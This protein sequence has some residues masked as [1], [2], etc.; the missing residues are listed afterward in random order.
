MGRPFENGLLDLRRNNERRMFA[1]EALPFF[2]EAMLLRIV[3]YSGDELALGIEDPDRRGENIEVLN[4]LS[5]R[6]MKSETCMI[7]QAECWEMKV[8]RSFLNSSTSFPSPYS[9]T[10]IASNTRMLRKWIESE[11]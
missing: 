8:N 9:I 2:K 3:V 1:Q 10:L 11:L 5:T 4:R 7:H 6:W